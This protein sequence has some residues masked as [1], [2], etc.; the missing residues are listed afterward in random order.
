LGS[1]HPASWLGSLF[2]SETFSTIQLVGRPNTGVGYY[3]GIGIGLS[4]YSGSA[5]AVSSARSGTQKGV[6]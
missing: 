6:A 3:L 1:S 4:T 2:G 5:R